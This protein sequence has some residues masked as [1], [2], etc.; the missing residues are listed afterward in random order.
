MT[1]F[2]LNNKIKFNN[3]LIKELVL[4]KSTFELNPEIQRLEKENINLQNQC[5]HE[6]EGGICKWCYKREQ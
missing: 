5:E 4:A 6:F 3:E 2:E 1:N